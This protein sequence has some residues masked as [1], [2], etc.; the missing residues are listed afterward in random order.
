MRL[1]AVVLE[2]HARAAMQLRD[3]D[4]FGAVDDER[5]VVRH[6][7]N[8]AHVDFLL[9]HLLDGLLGRLLIH[10]DQARLGAQRGAVG[11]AA[12]LALRNVERGRQ[13][14]EP[15]ELQPRVA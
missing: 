3:D 13:Q 2:E 8:L 10:D 9:F 15:D 12:L 7:R 6:E 4:A 1:A 11:K 14:G 5:A